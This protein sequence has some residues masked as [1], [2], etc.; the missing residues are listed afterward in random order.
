[1]L[2]HMTVGALHSGVNLV[3]RVWWISTFEEPYP[4]KFDA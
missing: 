3:S 4:V 2:S 1:M